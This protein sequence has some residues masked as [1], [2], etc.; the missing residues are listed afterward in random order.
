MSTALIQNQTP[1]SVPPHFFGVWSRQSI[2]FPDGQEDNST[3]V[4]W[5]QANPHFADLRIPISR[6][7]FE[8]I[9]SL[10]ECGLNH[11]QWMGIQ[12]GFS[13]ALAAAEEA[14]QWHRE[15]DFQPPTGKRD[16]GTL[17]LDGT[18]T[19]LM[20]EQGVD[21]PN[22]ETWQR[23]DDGSSTKGQ[24]LVLRRRNHRG[25]A[26]VV[27][28]GKHF[29]MTID[30]RKTTSQCERI[31]PLNVEISHGT[32][33]GPISQWTVEHST[34]P[35]REGRPLFGGHTAQIN[36][37]RRMLLEAE[38]WQIV[39]PAAGKLDWVY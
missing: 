5:I 22:T 9:S 16:I 34:F 31:D 24:A 32:R 39:E 13:G 21:E 11:R 35:W 12:Q 28:L 23:V 8:G 30:H 26:L 1:V 15:I 25:H 19:K 36:W 7:D 6:P 20:I 29:I 18:D 10:T 2:R 33:S 17:K 14:W 3:R 27:A 4:W 38:Q 37:R